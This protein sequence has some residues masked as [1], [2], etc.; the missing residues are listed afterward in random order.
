MVSCAL[1]F[2]DGDS[3]YGI[4]SSDNI[5]LFGE[6]V[7][8]TGM[9]GYQAT[10]TDISYTGQILVMSAVEIG[11][12]GINLFE[13]QADR[14]SI[15]ALIVRN[16]SNSL[17]HRDS[18]ISLER[19]LGDFNIPI[20]TG[21]ETRAVIRKLVKQKISAYASIKSGIHLRANS[22]AM[23]ERS[24]YNSKRSLLS[25]QKIEERLATKEKTIVMVDFGFKLA[26]KKKLEEITNNQ[27]LIVNGN[28]ERDCRLLREYYTE[29]DGIVIS[30]GPGD[31]MYYRE[32]I[33]RFAFVK[34]NKVHTLG[35]CLGHQLLALLYGIA[36]EKLH[37][38]HRSITHPVLDRSNGKIQI[39]SHNHG[40]T[41]S[42]EKLADS[43][44]TH[45]SL[46]DQTIEGAIWD[47]KV[48]SVQFHPEASPGTNE[49]DGVFNHLSRVSEQKVVC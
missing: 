47:S 6:T 25:R 20:I 7:F 15:A 43:Q 41:I 42:R 23:K 36:T 35:I 33:E 24:V 16:L 10:L 34:E 27:L 29:L 44:I 31:P 26:I 13:S 39:T 4:S 19:F 9:T 3:F 28:S 22:I 14:P 1:I 5:N 46:V 48:R 21:I 8:C 2:E 38:G 49:G 17:S 30:N 11:N 45:I 12:V 37:Y 32:S 18:Y 40:Y